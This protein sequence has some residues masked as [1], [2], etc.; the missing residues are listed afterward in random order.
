[1]ILVEELGELRETRNVNDDGNPELSLL[2]W[3]SAT[4]IP[5]EEVGPKQARSAE[6]L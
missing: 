3:E 1:M 5:E 2:R 6:G 4:T